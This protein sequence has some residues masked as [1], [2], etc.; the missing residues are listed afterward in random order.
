MARTGST[1]LDSSD[2]FP[3]LELQLVSGEKLKLPDGMGEGY[4]VILIY[5]G[6]W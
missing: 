4:S 3:Q 5:R 6:H 1:F 2:M